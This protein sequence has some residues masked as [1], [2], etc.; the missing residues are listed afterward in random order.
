M[1]AVAGAAIFLIAA[2]VGGYTYYRSTHFNKNVQINGVSVGGLSEKSALAHLKSEKINND[3]YLNGKLFLKGK[4]TNSGFTQ[5]DLS[6]VKELLKKQWSF[7]PRSKKISYQITPSNVSD[8][9]NKV[10]KPKLK[11]LLN[12]KNSKLTAAVDSH[13]VLQYGKISYTV[14]KKGNQYDVAKILAAYE[15][16]KNQPT[17]N[18]KKYIIQPVTSLSS[19]VQKQKAKLETLAKRTVVYKV[20]QTSYT[21]SGKNV[22]SQATY[23]GGKYQIAQDGILNEVKNINSKQATLQKGISFKTHA[24]NVVNV[25]G[26][27]YGWALKGS[28]SYETISNAF[29]NNSGE[30]DAASDIY[31]VGYLT[32]GTGYDNSANDGIGTTYAEVSIQDQRAWFYING[33]EV[34]TTNIV[35]GKH[36]TNEDTPTGVWY[37]MYKQSP[38]TLEGS[39]AGNANYSVKVNYWAQFTSSGCG[40]HDASWRT[41]WSSTAYLNN[42]S[43]GCA[44]T[45]SANM[46]SVY[47]SLSQKEAVVVY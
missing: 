14:S 39:E 24:G 18:I 47:D 8:Y 22:I 27:T 26:G 2:I 4:K 17:T 15:K 46:K 11:Q 31:G 33:K 37:I 29:I 13:A 35:T 16:Q 9:R 30:V 42:G 43:G 36:S 41:D 10:I 3:V 21:L 1:L 32:Y 7:F 23:I 20:Q 19:Q 25:P 40:F 12:S 6:K 5:K 28:D 44:N 34:Y 45:P 38:A